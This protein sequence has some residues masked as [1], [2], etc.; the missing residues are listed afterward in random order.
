LARFVLQ[1]AKVRDDW[2][3][4]DRTAEP[5]ELDWPKLRQLLAPHGTVEGVATL[6]RMKPRA[7]IGLKRAS[8]AF[9]Q[10]GIK[11]T[12]FMFMDSF[13]QGNLRWL[14]KQQPTFP[15][16]IESVYRIEVV[17]WDER[18][19]DL[20]VSKGRPKEAVR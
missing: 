4:V 18:L 3:V 6:R 8:P 7:F 2:I 9:Q 14:I 1:P 20:G 10:Q 12:N 5:I 17:Q 13:G 11:V 16:Q 15:D 19:V